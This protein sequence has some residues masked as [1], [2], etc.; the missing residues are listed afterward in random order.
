MDQKLWLNDG[1]IS[2]NAA[3]INPRDRGFT[4][5]D[6][7]FETMRVREGKILHLERHLARL[8]HGTDVIALS[9]PWTDAELA[10]AIAQ[11]LTANDLQEAYVRLTVSR[12]VPSLRGLLPDQNAK[13]T[14]LIQ[15]EHFT[16]YPAE[17]Y[18]RGMRV[19]TSSI[20]RNECSPLANIKSLNYLDNIL[21]RQEAMK[22]GADDALMLNTA[23]NIA[24]AS[25]ANIFFVKG[26][27]LITPPLS[28]GA[29]PGTMR[30]Y[31]FSRVQSLQTS[32]FKTQNL[33]VLDSIHNVE[34][35]VSPAEI[36][37]M[38]EAFLTNALMGV[39]PLV[40][41]EGEILG[42]GKPGKI[43]LSL[44]EK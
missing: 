20:R 16:G 8:R 34:R 14:L 31:V 36:Y 11:T 29:L 21:A 18:Q 39:M 12:G 6:G 43:T 23:G 35:S 40:S 25:A 44:A 41:V 24:C 22:K 37:Q 19:I 33:E 27:R 17:L 42:A 30:A 1:L 38:D 2:Y 5:G 7:L 9:L 10:E 32:A 3:R 28:D 26:D 15:A 4:L 13:L